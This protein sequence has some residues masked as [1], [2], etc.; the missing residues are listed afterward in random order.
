MEKLIGLGLLAVVEWMIM[1]KFGFEEII[2]I[3]PAIVA[4]GLWIVWMILELAEDNKSALE[5]LSDSILNSINNYP[6]YIKGV[7]ENDIDTIQGC[8]NT[9]H[10]IPKHPAEYINLKYTVTKEGVIFPIKSGVI[11]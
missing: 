8:T 11:Q 1:G 2:M 3:N 5:D 9:L 6:F 7:I 10:I 4:S